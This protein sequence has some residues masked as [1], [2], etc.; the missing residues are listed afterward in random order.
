MVIIEMRLVWLTCVLARAQ[1]PHEQLQ[2][3]SYVRKSLLNIF[4]TL[5]MGIRTVIDVSAMFFS[6]VIIGM[7][8]L[9]FEA[10]QFHQ[11][12][13]LACTRLKRARESSYEHYRRKA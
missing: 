4:L 8:S 1:H 12:E 5:Q 9:R 10:S 11:Y 2:A 3:R 13:T 7:E 6:I